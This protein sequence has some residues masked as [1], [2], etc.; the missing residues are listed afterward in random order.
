MHRLTWIHN[1]WVRRHSVDTT[2]TLGGIEVFPK[3]RIRTDSKVAAASRKT[4]EVR[5]MPASILSD[6]LVQLLLH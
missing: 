4:F 6:D 3:L 1:G 2:S 5:T